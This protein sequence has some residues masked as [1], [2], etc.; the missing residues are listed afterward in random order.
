[1]NVMVKGAN[2]VV[3]GCDGSPWIEGTV[4]S[5]PT[6]SS[7]PL[8]STVWPKISGDERLYRSP[9]TGSLS[10][11]SEAPSMLRTKRVDTAV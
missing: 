9:A 10:N 8:R 1:M 3:P 2:L 4:P 7:L 11:A 6:L 5:G